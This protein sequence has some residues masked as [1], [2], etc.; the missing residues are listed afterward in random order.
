MQRVILSNDRFGKN[1][2]KVILRLPTI[3]LSE[4]F[5]KLN[6]LNNGVEL[7]IPIKTWNYMQLWE[8]KRRY[9]CSTQTKI[10][11][12]QPNRKLRFNYLAKTPF[13]FQQF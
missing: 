5:L 6:W 8:L 1:F 2:L 11:T 10:D 4:Y 9:H 13:F 7:S 3:L 12:M